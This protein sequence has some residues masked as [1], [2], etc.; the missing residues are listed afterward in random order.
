M[1][2]FALALLV[3]IAPWLSAPASHAASA[4]PSDAFFDRTGKL[5]R[6]PFGTLAELDEALE[7]V[8][9]GSGA[10]G[11]WQAVQSLGQMPLVFGNTAV[12]MARA[13]ATSVAW[14]GDFNRWQARG[15]L[16]G[17]RV[18]R[19]D[20]WTARRTFPQDARLDYTLVVDGR[21][22]LDPLNPLT[23]RDGYAVHS[24]LTLPG[25]HDSSWAETQAGTAGA[26]SATRSSCRAS[27]WAMQSGFRCTRP[28]GTR[29]CKTCPWC[30]S[31]TGRNTPIPGWARSRPSSTT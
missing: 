19:T 8:A 23:Q 20:I 10:E 14:T 15:A 28:P 6:V 18:G 5:A 29:D 13:N 22:R 21:Q 30:T 26:R 3:F 31:R 11:F 9:A 12:F 25:F 4:S 17:R 27:T 7:S 1:I 24:V 2:R 16:A